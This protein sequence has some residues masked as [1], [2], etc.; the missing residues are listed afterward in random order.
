MNLEFLGL[1]QLPA[2]VLWDMDGTIVDTESAWGELSETV[3]RE[4]GGIW[5]SED[6]EFILG[7]STAD[8]ANRLADAVARAGLERPE[9]MEI[10]GELTRLMATRAYPF[11][12]L[13]PGVREL[14]WAFRDAGVPQALV[15]A[16]PKDLVDIALESLGEMYFNAVVT[17]SDEVPGK[18]APDP[19]LLGAK[20]LGVNAEDALIFEDSRAG[21]EAARASGA[22]V[23]D[24]NHT[25]PAMLARRLGLVR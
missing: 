9:S 17:G 6:T 3:I 4:A 5:E 7:A 23:V 25:A 15:T 10:F 2:A 24:V 8:H 18:P 11:V 12:R 20:R 16:T 1:S 19:Y 13:L 22:V 14:L 21:L